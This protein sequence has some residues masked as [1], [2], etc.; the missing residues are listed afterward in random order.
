M[1]IFS[2][3]IKLSS[4]A[5]NIIDD[6]KYERDSIEEP[7]MFFYNID[8]GN[9]TLR[10]TRRK[11][12]FEISM[13]VDNP[14]M[15]VMWD[16]TMKDDEIILL[17][18]Y[19]HSCTPFNKIDFVITNYGIHPF[20][21]QG[22]GLLEPRSISRHL[23]TALRFCKHINNNKLLKL[24]YKMKIDPKEQLYETLSIV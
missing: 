12:C 6:S 1:G 14:N 8:T 22:L 16:D 21:L 7:S 17:T 3:K 18:Q 15:I 2:S 13:F 5:E 24:E 19:I 20:I 9:E 23:L 4:N 11:N 10:V